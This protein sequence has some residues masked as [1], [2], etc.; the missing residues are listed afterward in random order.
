[1]NRLNLSQTN[2]R[3]INNYICQYWS[4]YFICTTYVYTSMWT[5]ISHR[6]QTHMN[7]YVGHT[8][9]SMKTKIN[10][11]IAFRLFRICVRFM[12][13]RAVYRYYLFIYFSHKFNFFSNFFINKK[14]FLFLSCKMACIKKL[15]R[16]EI[17]NKFPLQNELI[18]I[19]LNIYM[20]MFDFYM[21]YAFKKFYFLSFVNIF[22]TKCK[23]RCEI[24]FFSKFVIG[25]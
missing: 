7:I 23:L 3:K 13:G 22:H 8:F 5:H 1:M 4:W 9:Y 16:Y 18:P 10:L 25:Q 11:Q 15:M 14:F 17:K 21:L 6:I 19:L 20:Y 12:F 2:I 24:V